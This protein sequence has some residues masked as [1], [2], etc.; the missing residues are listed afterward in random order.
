MSIAALQQ[1]AS[2][3][4]VLYPAAQAAMVHRISLGTARVVKW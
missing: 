1:Y 3:W 2:L 4:Q